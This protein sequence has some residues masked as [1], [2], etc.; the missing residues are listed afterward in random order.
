MKFLITILVSFLLL[1]VSSCHDDAKF[2]YIGCCDDPI[3]SRDSFGDA[4]IFLPNVFTPN[5]DGI[6][7]LYYLL[8]DSIRRI[9]NFE[10][11]D[12]FER[13]VYRAKNYDYPGV[14]NAWDGKVS[15]V[16]EKGIY[17][18]FLTIETNDGI[19]GN[20]EARVCNYPCGI[21][22]FHEDFSKTNCQLEMQWFCQKHIFEDCF[23]T[24]PCFDH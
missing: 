8:G 23:A 15:G 20:I 19:V 7:D 12:K 3:I 18:V 22:G 4:V 13:L 11:R 16:V 17:S 14:E 24:E 10:I 6:N 5:E 21:D 9:L 2:A 1:T